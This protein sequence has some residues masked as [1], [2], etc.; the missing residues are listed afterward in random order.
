MGAG[1]VIIVRGGE[2]LYLFVLFVIHALDFVDRSPSYGW[3]RCLT[4][5]N[6]PW[7]EKMLQTLMDRY[8]HL[9]CS[10]SAS[11]ENLLLLHK[12]CPP[13]RRLSV[14]RS[15]NYKVEPSDLLK[16]AAQLPEY[17]GSHHII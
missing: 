11:Q 6:V 10:L 17:L 12:Y 4:S 1:Y 13:S 2:S 14:P 9:R 15:V 5:D 3:V 8:F 7:N 16:P